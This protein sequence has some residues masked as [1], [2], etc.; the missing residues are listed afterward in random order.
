M[1]GEQVFRLFVGLAVGIWVA[2][3]LGPSKFGELSYAISFAAVFGVVV[4]LGLN[5]ILVRELVSAHQQQHLVSQLMCTAF[6][7]RIAASVPM[8]AI[9]LLA[10]FLVGGEGILLVG[11]VAGSFFF[12]ASD[13]VE[14]Y[15]QSRVQARI[16]ARARLVSFIFVTGV[17]IG[18]LL[19]GA[20]VVAFAT[21]SLL[22]SAGGA[23]VLQRIYRRHGMQLSSQMIDWR[24]A[25]R[26]LAESWPE[27]L[28]GFTGLLFVRLD[29]IMLQHMAGPE[30]VG[31]F[32]VAARL[33]EAW[34]FVPSAIIASTFP[35]IVAS[36]AIDSELYMRKLQILLAVLCILS[37]VVAIFVTAAAEPVIEALYGVSYAGSAPI[38]VVLGWC[39][40]FVSL[41]LASGSWIMAERKV[42]L[43]LYRH[44]AGLGANIALNLFLIP[45]FGAIGAAYS[46]LL[47]LIVAYMIFDIFAPSMKEISRRKWRAILIMP[48][49]TSS[50]W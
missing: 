28:A 42:R 31:M 8:Y 35:G 46:T 39:G 36:K 50:R 26:L 11:L 6:A 3:L 47:S 12:N 9:C 41:G 19:A 4:T 43:N 20:D 23:Y 27:I 44:V 7:M 10:A 34:Y 48:M 24:L 17:R 49:L 45:R 16:T 14:L 2:R 38:L 15:F 13:V 32:A 25:R 5:R 40:L 30:A 29:Q 37:Y 22:E 1:M 33:S 18:L 21:I